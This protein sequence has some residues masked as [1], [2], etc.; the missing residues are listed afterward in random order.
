MALLA[1]PASVHEFRALEHSEVLEHGGAI[2]LRYLGA[3]GAGGARARFQYV[4]HS[5]THGRGERFEDEI[6]IEG[7]VASIIHVI[8]IQHE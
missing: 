6:I 5:T 7:I 1:D 4:E 8:K 3:Q 2:Q